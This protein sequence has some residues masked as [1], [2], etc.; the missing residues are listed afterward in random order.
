VSKHVSGSFRVEDWN[1]AAYVEAEDGVGKLARASVKQSFSGDIEG[2]GQVEWLLCYR[3]DQTAD[4]VGLQRISGRVGE[5]SGSFVLQ[6]NGVFDGKEARGDLAVVVG[7]G[8]DELRG[9]TGRG[10]FRAPLGGR[11]P[12][13][14]LEY[15]IED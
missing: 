2:A 9:I 8:T 14:S 13:V 6:S 5:R 15:E 1:E 3:P 11:E 10:E 7:S 4:F 12:T